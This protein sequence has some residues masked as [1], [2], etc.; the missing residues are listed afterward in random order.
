MDKQTIRETVWD[1][2]EEGGIARFPFPPHDRIPNF[3]GANEAA[4]RLT[5]TQS[6]TPRRR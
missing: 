1:A 6:G 5:E 4:Q 3:E 2:L